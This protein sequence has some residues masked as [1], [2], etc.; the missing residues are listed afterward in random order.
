MLKNIFLGSLLI[1]TACFANAR[2]LHPCTPSRQAM[3]TKIVCGDQ[4]LSYVI[5]I[6]TLMSPPEICQGKDYY[7][8]KTAKIEISADS[9]PVGKVEIYDG[10]FDYSLGTN[11]TSFR[12]EVLSLNLTDCVS[13]VHGGFSV[14]NK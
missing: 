9:K 13:P 7:E 11:R 2:S 1:F 6:E 4:H 12:S 3:P 5:V 10:Q 14:G 8:Y